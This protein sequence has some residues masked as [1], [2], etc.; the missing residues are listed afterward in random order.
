[1]TDSSSTNQDQIEENPYIHP[2]IENP[3]IGTIRIKV[4]ASGGGAAKI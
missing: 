3:G 1:M 4:Q 2:K